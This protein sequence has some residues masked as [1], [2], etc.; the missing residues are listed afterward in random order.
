[1]GNC[2][3]LPCVR[4]PQK[5]LRG[6]GKATDSATTVVESATECGNNFTSPTRTSLQVG[7]CLKELE[8]LLASSKIAY[9]DGGG[10]RKVKIVV[11]KEQFELLLANAKKLQSRHRLLSYTVPRRGCQKWRPILS[12][13]AEEEDF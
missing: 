7:E 1:M 2:V 6:L 4:S 8:N 12:A 9:S 3:V 13:I 11:T 5:N 10:A